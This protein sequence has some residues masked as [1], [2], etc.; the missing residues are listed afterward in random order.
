MGPAQ[1]IRSSPSPRDHLATKAGDGR[2]RLLAKD[3]L[4]S[5]AVFIDLFGLANEFVNGRRIGEGAFGVEPP[6]L[7]AKD[8]VAP[9][10][11]RIGRKQHVM[12]ALQLS[13]GSGRVALNHASQR[14]IRKQAAPQH[15]VACSGIG[16]HQRIHVLKIK[17]VA[18]IGTGNGT[19]SSVSP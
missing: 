8:R 7:H 5:S 12:E 10:L 15:Y 3:A 16:L 18:V 4:D 14:G 2:K 19:R 1:A 17:D 9:N 6:L 13:G 11:V